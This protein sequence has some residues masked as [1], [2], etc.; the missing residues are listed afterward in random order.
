M[1]IAVLCVGKIREPYFADAISEYRKRIGRYADVE[2]IETAD[3]PAPERLSDAQIRQIKGK[4][5]RRLLE[6]SSPSAF[7]IAL[8]IDGRRMD[9]IGFSECLSEAMTHGNSRIEF[10]IGGS[11]GLSDEVIRSAD[12]RLSFSDLTFPHQLMRVILLEQIYR[13]FKIMHHEPY[14]K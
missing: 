2:I 1:K 11:N 5:G 3:E 9:S 7:R 14:H 13:A 8:C 12:L 6:K 4:E 10:F